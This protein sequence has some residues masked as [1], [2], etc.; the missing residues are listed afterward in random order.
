METHQLWSSEHCRSMFGLPSDCALTT[1]TLLRKVHP[2]DQHV[3]VA[4]I[5]AATFGTPGDH[6]SEFRVH[7]SNDETAWIQARGRTALHNGGTPVRISGIFR[8]ITARRLAQ[9]E[10]KQL[11]GRLLSIQ[12]EERQ[13]IAGEL[14]DS[15]AQHLA[16]VS[17]NLMALKGAKGSKRK[18]AIFADLENLLKTAM[19]EIRTVSY[20]LYPQEVANGRL[21]ETLERYV[22]GFRRRTGLDVILRTSNV[23][24]PLPDLLQQSM[25]RIVQESLGNVHRHASAAR[26]TVNLRRVANRLHVVITDDGRGMHLHNGGVPAMGVGITGMTARARQLG[27]KLDIRSRS[28]RTIVH[29]VLPTSAAKVKAPD[30]QMPESARPQPV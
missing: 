13:R 16:A 28:T 22:E 6:V 25:L 5:R 9:L 19:G 30:R 21:I 8:D 18:A 17:L 1:E 27:G 12:D 3:A 24:G 23:K 14:H 11:S 7:R 29:A 4:A 26:A 15:T 10:A 20:V 2:E